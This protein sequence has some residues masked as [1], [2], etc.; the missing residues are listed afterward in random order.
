MRVPTAQH[1]LLLRAA[2]LEG[3]P[4]PTAWRSWR[5]AG[6]LGSADP[7]AGRL[8]PLVYRNLAALGFDDADLR[9]VKGAY[10]AAWYANQLVVRRA[11]DALRTLHDAGIE[12]IAL[13]GLGLSARYYNDWGARPLTEAPVLVPNR[14]VDRAARLAS[15]ALVVRGRTLAQRVG[16]EAV[17]SLAQPVTVGG[18][19]TR[20]LAPTDQLLETILCG[21]YWRLG[22]PLGW[23]ADAAVVIRRAGEDVDRERLAAESAR[24][25]VTLWVLSALELLVELVE[26]PVPA[27]A[28]E[29]LR[30]TR[31]RRLERRAHRAVSRS[32]DPFPLAAIAHRYR[33][34]SALDPSIGPIDF[35]QQQAGVARSGELVGRIAR[36]I[37]RRVSAWPRAAFARR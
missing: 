9:R 18:V 28:L 22:H 34:L 30:L 26:A 27:E 17:W 8:F 7:L 29:R 23:L 35:L 19:A 13:G 3:E 4:A 20:A 25:G 11:A 10:A 32:A 14:V 12:T 21:A 37:G 16:D 6:T 2:L 1:A 31:T 24:C 33:H 15:A 36:A 5:A